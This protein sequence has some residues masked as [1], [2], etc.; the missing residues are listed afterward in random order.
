MGISERLHGFI[1]KFLQTYGYLKEN[2]SKEEFLA[3]IKLF[4]SVYGMA[5]HGELDE[6]TVNAFFYKRCQVPDFLPF[7]ASAYKWNKNKLTYYIKNRDRDLS[8]EIWDEAIRK[9]FHNWTDVANMSFSQVSSSNADII[10]EIGSGPRDEFD[11][12]SGTLAWAQLPPGNNSQ[13]LMKFDV[14]ETWVT[15]PGNR[16]ILLTNVACHEIGHLLGLEHS[17]VQSALMA[18]YYSESISTP[19]NR[20]DIPRIQNLYGKPVSNPNPNPT[21]NPIPSPTPAPS[22][23]YKLEVT[24]DL[25]IEGYRLVKLEN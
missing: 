21:P 2:F 4:Q 20:D 3:A 18:P 17:R 7:R 8:P 24:G 9:A 13:L 15:N 25:K 1:V 5:S 11:G 14:A 19:Q 23:T 16:G 6:K 12:P 22:K 10:M